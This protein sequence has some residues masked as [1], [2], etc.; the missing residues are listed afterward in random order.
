[1]EDD[2]I[3]RLGSRGDSASLVPMREQQPQTA[4]GQPPHTPSS[5][6][7]MWEVAIERAVLKAVTN[8]WDTLVEAAQRRKR[9]NDGVFNREE[10]QD[11]TSSALGDSLYTAKRPK[12]GRPTAQPV[13]RYA[14]TR[15]SG[16]T[17]TLPNMFTAP[18][19]QPSS[20][21]FLWT[22]IAEARTAIASEGIQVPPTFSIMGIH[23]NLHLAVPP[24]VR[25]K[26]Y[27]TIMRHLKAMIL[28]GRDLTQLMNSRNRSSWTCLPSMVSNT[29]CDWPMEGRPGQYACRVCTRNFGRPCVIA[30]D[31]DL[32][33]LPLAPELRMN[34][35]SADTAF[36]IKRQDIKIPETLFSID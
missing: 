25:S 16:S 18:T 28:M 12:L 21:T 27:G 32:F 14:V 35:M 10:Q 3:T 9:G 36:F 26:A 19:V 11:T 24:R 4:P 13:T 15:T 2:Q 17:S 23:N 1:M 6:E 5:G 34:V 7:R 20:G 31:G 33:V 8:N 30:I 22:V 29:T